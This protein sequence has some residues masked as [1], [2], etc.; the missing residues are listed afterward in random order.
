MVH[1]EKGECREI[2]MYRVLQEQAKK[3]MIKEALKEGEEDSSS[4]TPSVYDHDGGVSIYS[5]EK[6]N[7]PITAPKA[8][9]AIQPVGDLID[10]DAESVLTSKSHPSEWEAK[11]PSAL[12]SPR[13][14]GVGVPA[15][16]ETI[17]A[18]NPKWDANKFFNPF[19]SQYV[20][21]CG[22]EFADIAGFEEHLL[23]KAQMNQRVRY[24]AGSRALPSSVSL[25]LGLNTNYCRCPGCQR[26]FNSMSALVAHCETGSR[27]CDINTSDLFG[28]IMDEMTGGVVQVAGYH[29]D[30]SLKYEAGEL[31]LERYTTVG[32][33]W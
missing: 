3:L 8:H 32:T 14:F 26:I 27:R 16:G 15:A 1:I 29:E 11:G 21:T 33:K 25:I 2:S 4:A 22:K 13:P 10:F 20:C 17:R 30:G 19:S 7:K 23:Q 6:E 28:Q 24:V 31:E 9:L 5:L 18:F 12:T